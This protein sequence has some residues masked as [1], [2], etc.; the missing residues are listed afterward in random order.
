V[1][2]LDWDDTILPTTWLTSKR[3]FR[4]WALNKQGAEPEVPSEDREALAELDHTARA[5]VLAASQLGR[6]CCITLAKRPWQTRSMQA[7]FPRLSQTWQELNVEVRYADE[8]RCMKTGDMPAW[9]ASAVD[10]LEQAV[11]REEVQAKKKQRAMQHLLR[12]F[13]RKARWRNVLSFGDGWAEMR[14]LHEIAFAQPGDQP[15]LLVKT[16]KM[17]EDP[18]CK[19]LCAELQVITA[20]LPALVSLDE[21][22]DVVFDES[23]ES[24]LD[25]HQRLLHPAE[26]ASSC[27]KGPGGPEAS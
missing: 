17:L 9:V 18:D 12:R 23:E 10:P 25:M 15:G 5:F 8:E 21:D 27:T 24:F 7:F 20:W 11:V 6:V 14:A 4:L 22:V 1:E 26:A 19:R 16:V 13:Y 2:V 3:W